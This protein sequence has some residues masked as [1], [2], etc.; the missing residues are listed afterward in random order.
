MW[1]EICR[2]VDKNLKET[3]YRKI[4]GAALNDCK[5]GVKYPASFF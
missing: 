1:E 2:Y 4:K 5:D 3:H